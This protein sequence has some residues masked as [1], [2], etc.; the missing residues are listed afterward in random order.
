MYQ[1]ESGHICNVQVAEQLGAN[2]SH[3]TDSQNQTP[4]PKLYQMSAADDVC[5]AIKTGAEAA[6]IKTVEAL[7]GVNDP[8]PT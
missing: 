8:T 2:F 5:D 7:G 6:R 1:K 3:V 4:K